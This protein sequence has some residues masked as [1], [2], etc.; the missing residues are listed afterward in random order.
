MSFNI[1]SFAYSLN[2]I[3]QS[4]KKTFNEVNYIFKENQKGQL[5]KTWHVLALCLSIFIS[6]LGAAFY[7][8]YEPK[9]LITS[10][11][12]PVNLGKVFSERVMIDVSVIG[13]TGDDVKNVVNGASYY[14]KTE[15]VNKNFNELFDLLYFSEE[16]KNKIKYD[17]ATPKSDNLLKL[18]IRTYIV[19]SS[20]NF[21]HN[22]YI[23]QI[24]EETYPLPKNVLMK[25]SIENL[26]NKNFINT[27]EDV[28]K[29]LFITDK[30][31]YDLVSTEK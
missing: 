15:P 14:D 7:I 21:M 26:I 22:P 28:I 1:F 2:N 8:V 13:I 29:N 9:S 27:Q 11:Y 18:K 17:E 25:T 30:S 20:S 12:G 19:Y 16:E 3:I 31:Q 24:K 5:V 6:I 10:N 4:R 23:L